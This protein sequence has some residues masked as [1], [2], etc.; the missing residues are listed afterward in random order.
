[1]ENNN[2][3]KKR[4]THA[5]LLNVDG[6][7]LLCESPPPNNEEASSNA[8]NASKRPFQE[9]KEGGQEYLKRIRRI[10]TLS[11]DYDDFADTMAENGLGDDD[12]KKTEIN[13]A[14]ASS[15]TRCSVEPFLL[16]SDYVGSNEE[17]SENNCRATLQD[18]TQNTASSL[19]KSDLN[20]IHYVVGFP[21]TMT[22]SN[23]IKQKLGV[24]PRD[25]S[26]T[27]NHTKSTSPPSS[28]ANQFASIVTPDESQVFVQSPNW[29][30]EHHSMLCPNQPA[31]TTSVGFVAL[32][33]KPSRYPCTEYANEQQEPSK[34][35]ATKSDPSK[36][37][38]EKDRNYH[39]R[40]LR[41]PFPE[42]MK[43]IIRIL[44]YLEQ[45]STDQ[46]VV[47]EAFDIVQNCYDYHGG[48]ESKIRKLTGAIFESLVEQLGQKVD[49]ASVLQEA[50]RLESPKLEAYFRRPEVCKKP[51]PAPFFPTL[52]QLA[53]AY[54][55]HSSKTNPEIISDLEEFVCTGAKDVVSM[56]SAEK[57]KF[58]K[59]MVEAQHAQRR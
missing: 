42:A 9:L 28:P 36:Q 40:L 30:L 47:H 19:N 38:S 12:N 52:L 8:R 22:E 7:R 27:R 6:R 32:K 29:N 26:S 34:Y 3:R 35:I 20:S 21:R 16:T 43:P 11:I 25:A 13:N 37:F 54:G 31:T 17:T 50:Q 23:H 18:W 57:V 48:E 56:N 39:P 14:V 15:N 33:P 49:L 24:P 58:W 45:T 55:A 10:H 59:S 4:Y 5:K 1:M 44:L 41:G 2:N 51:T 46:D 53:V